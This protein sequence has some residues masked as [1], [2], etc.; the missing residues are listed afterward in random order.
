MSSQCLNCEF[1][2]KLLD[3]CP[4]YQIDQFNDFPQATVWSQIMAY[5]SVAPFA[6]LP[7]FF[8]MIIYWNTYKAQRNMGL[9]LAI[10]IAMNELLI[11][12]LIKQERPVGACADSYGMP[13]SHA[14]IMAILFIYYINQ[15]S[16]S[17]QY[18][19]A[20]V[21]FFLGVMTCYSRI[22]LGY[23][24]KEQVFAGL[25]Y[26]TFISLLFDLF[27]DEVP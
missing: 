19:N 12:N 21:V 9:L 26:G 2:L 3:S 7:Y 23:H 8:F 15:A 1:I 24:S 22:Y 25:G 5:S 10:A 18:R 4:T 27:V 11:K 14:A 6:I 16:T 17:G 13:S 20:F